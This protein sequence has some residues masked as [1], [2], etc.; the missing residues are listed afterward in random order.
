MRS[1]PRPPPCRTLFDATSLTASTRSSQRGA[2][3]ARR[4]RAAGDEAGARRPGPRR[5]SRTCAPARA[6][7]AADR[8]NGARGGVERRGSYGCAGACRRRTTAAMAAM[9]LRDHARRASAPVSYGQRNE[10]GPASAK[11]RLS[12]DSCRWHST[13][14]ASLRPAQIGSP[15]PQIAPAGGSVRVD[16]LAP[17]RYQ[18]RGIGADLAH[19]GEVHVLRRQPPARS[20]AA[21]SCLVDGDDDGI[22]CRE[23]VPDERHAPARN[24]SSPCVQERVVPERL[25]A[26]RAL[27]LPPDRCE[28]MAQAWS[29]GSAVPQVRSAPRVRL[30]CLRPGRQGIPEFRLRW[31]MRR[32]AAARVE[33]VGLP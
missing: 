2:A 10:S 14:S 29:R 23:P 15:S 13:S 18:T 24:S 1:V 11:A 32:P 20:P 4:A 22:A 8:A 30:P 28:R 9:R 21:R 27:K 7:P 25:S 33:G 17:G 12:S 31:P 19:V 16:E 5:R 3:E 26:P 6:A